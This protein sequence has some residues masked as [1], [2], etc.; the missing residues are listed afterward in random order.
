MTPIWLT[1]GWTRPACAGYDQSK[2]NPHLFC[3]WHWAASCP[4]WA[5]PR[6][7]AATTPALCAPWAAQALHPRLLRA[8]LSSLQRTA[9]FLVRSRDRYPEN[10]LLFVT[11]YKHAA[12]TRWWI[13]STLLQTWESWCWKKFG[14]FLGLSAN[15]AS[16]SGGWG[17]AGD[18]TVC[19]GRSVRHPCGTTPP[20]RL[21]ASVTSASVSSNYAG[22]RLKCFISKTV[23][24]SANWL[25]SWHWKHSKNTSCLMPELIQKMR[26]RSGI[27]WVKTWW[28]K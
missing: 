11:K 18:W 7:R 25:P 27:L 13:R 15:D 17:K 10:T 28:H 20:T 5:P 14:R 19:L 26:L 24:Y 12:P 2:S 6:W 22:T 4:T 21:Q 23:F 16:W 9:C 8:R 1:V 3:P